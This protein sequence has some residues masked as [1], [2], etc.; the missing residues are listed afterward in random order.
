MFKY[1][2]KKHYKAKILV[3]Q[4]KVW[5]LEFLKDQ[6]LLMREGF[7][8]EYDSTKERI[9]ALVSY[10]D[11]I[12]RMGMEKAKE[13]MKNPEKVHEALRDKAENIQLSQEERDTIE[14][15]EKDIKAKTE[16]TERL[17]K[18]METLD[19]QMEGPLPAG[20]NCLNEQIEG[21]RT[22]G[23]LLKDKIKKL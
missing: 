21:L 22:I 17:K 1:T 23:G 8:N 7:R 5:D 9:D 3:T 15:L 11:L 10:K 20:Q 13:M 14:T 6:Y 19:M 12:T 4:K 18:Q 16:D 2:Q